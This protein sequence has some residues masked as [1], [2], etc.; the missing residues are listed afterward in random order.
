MHELNQI[1]GVSPNIGWQQECARA[2]LV[3]AYGLV[4]VRIVGRRVFG[5]W[6]VPI[7]V[8]R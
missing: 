7:S 6:L 1:F 3:L 2:A 8:E 5:K 4:V